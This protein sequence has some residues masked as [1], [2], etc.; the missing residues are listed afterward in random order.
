T[1]GEHREFLEFNFEEYQE[2]QRYAKEIGITFFSTAFDFPSANF[3]EELNMP[4]FKIASGDLR[5]IPLLK[6]IAEFQK[7]MII[8]TGAA[9]LEDVQRAYDAVMP[10][11][12]QVCFLQCTASYP[13]DH[14][15]LDLQVIAT[16]QSLFPE[17]VVGLSSHYSGIAMATAAYVLGGRVIEKH[18]TL[19]R[20]MKGTDHAFSLE[21]VGMRKLVRDLKRVREALGDGQKK[22]YLS[23]QG[24]RV[25]MGKK[26]VVT[27][28]LPAGHQLTAEDITMKSPGDGLPPYEIDNVIGRVLTQP[29]TADEAISLAFLT[30]SV[31]YVVQ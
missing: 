13:A 24:A 27:R 9:T 11:N 17:V 7:P 18:F 30:D 2:L 21:P 10:I 31:E 20:A 8:S 3:L 14:T 23:E 29:L 12:S 26:L 16:Y 15:E 22:F 28:D 19:N 5:S 1:Y 6:Y 25:K 4:A